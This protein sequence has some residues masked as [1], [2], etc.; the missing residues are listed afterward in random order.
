MIEK[1][2]DE[3]KSRLDLYDELVHSFEDTDRCMTDYRK[4]KREA[5]RWVLGRKENI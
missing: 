3:I 2:E 1:S 5:L 4:G